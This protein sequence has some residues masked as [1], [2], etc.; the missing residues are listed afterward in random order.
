MM[1]WLV[2]GGIGS[3]KSAFAHELALVVGREGI[4]LSCPPFPRANPTA[5]EPWAAA[6]EFYRTLSEADESLAHKLNAINMESN[7]FRAERRVVVVDSLSGW[8]RGLLGR[9]D[10]DNEEWN[11]L[12]EER[13]REALAAIAAF[14]GRMIVVTEEPSVGLRPSSEELAFAYWLAEA[15]RAL[16]AASGKAYRLTAGVAMELKGYQVKGGNGGHENLYEN[17]R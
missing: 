5:G 11:S 4:R 16:L 14:E 2:T 15:N 7:I 6:G 10:T 12:A 9:M 17:R 1:L 8:L 13:W 3:G